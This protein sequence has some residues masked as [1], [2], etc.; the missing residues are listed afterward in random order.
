MTNPVMIL[1]ERGIIPRGVRLTRTLVPRNQVSYQL[2][3]SNGNRATSTTKNKI[4]ATL[5]PEQKGAQ[6]WW[7][8]GRVIWV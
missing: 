7:E 3:T 4:H 8:I 1:F 2:N 6:G 5:L